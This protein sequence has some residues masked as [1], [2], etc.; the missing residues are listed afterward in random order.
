MGKGQAV[1][2]LDTLPLP[3]DYP[4][5]WSQAIPMNSVL[6]KWLYLP[7][8]FRAP[9]STNLI[10]ECSPAG[11]FVHMR[12]LPASLKVKEVLHGQRASADA[13]FSSQGACCPGLASWPNPVVPRKDGTGGSFMGAPSPAGSAHGTEA[14]LTCVHPA[15]RCVCP[16]HSGVDAKIVVG[17]DVGVDAGVDAGVHRWAERQMQVCTD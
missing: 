1:Q 14:L 5:R 12:R 11:F 13:P 16:R 7:D 17:M 4:W 9:N 2:S 15:I 10:S 3:T 8:F 6:I